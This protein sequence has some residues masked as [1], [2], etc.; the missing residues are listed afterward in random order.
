MPMF[1]L[2]PLFSSTSSDQVVTYRALQEESALHLFKQAEASKRK[3]LLLKRLTA[4]SG[5]A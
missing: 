3:G 2:V 5:A 4:R 1:G